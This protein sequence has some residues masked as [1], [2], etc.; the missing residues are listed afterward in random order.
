MRWIGS[1]PDRGAYESTYSD[2]TAYTVTTTADAGA[3]SL[4]Q[5]M[6][7]A[8]S[9]PNNASIG[10]NI[11]NP[12]THLPV[13]PAVIALAS[14]LPAITSPLQINGYTQGGSTL[15]DDAD[16]F[17]AK[18][19]VI[20][21][22]ASG[23]LS[24]GFRVPSTAA[25]SASLVLRGIGLGGFGQPV[26][27]L[28]GSNHVIAGNQFGGSVG[29]I[30]LPGAGLTAVSVGVGAGGSLIVGGQSVAD[31]NVIGGAQQGGINV[32]STLVNTP[33]KC[34]IVN[35]LIGLA[36]N[37]SAALANFTGINLDGQGCSVT[38][39]RIAGN[40]RD[41]IWIQGDGN[42][43]QRNTLGV[44][45]NGNGFLNS[46]AGVRITS[47]DGNI[48]G[49]SPASGIS[50]NLLANTI[51]YMGAGGVLIGGGSGNTVRSNRIYDNGI[52][53][54]G[55]DLDLGIDGVTANDSGDGDTGANNLQNFPLVGVVYFLAAPAP[56][57]T[58]VA[59]NAVATLNTLPGTYRVDA[60]YA[61][62]CDNGAFH[63]TGRGHAE[64]YVGTGTVTVAAGASNAAFALNV[65]LPDM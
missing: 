26:S 34:Q 19:C 43:V 29:A 24:V 22:P 33:D 64:T 35:N 65:T 21:M 38:G 1:A 23:N 37:G 13:C 61:H 62:R 60:Y 57:A 48:V 12:I 17:N 46:G 40:T 36:P 59:A 5:A 42:L 44:A 41:A 14:A 52:S 55:L 2:L 11:T 25:S 53:G 8:N 63:V 47:A 51:R 49:S 3:G 56:G 45:V 54:E 27:L 18:L 28:G 50:G 6:L 32:Q 7:D 16:A 10:F 4:R 9:L 15:N 30:S 58:Q 20:V 39:N 31:R